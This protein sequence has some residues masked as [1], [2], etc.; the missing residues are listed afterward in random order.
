MPLM[1]QL[2]FEQL[3]LQPLLADLPLDFLGLVFQG[4]PPVFKL[5]GLAPLLALLFELFGKLRELL[6]A[7][8]VERAELEVDDD[9]VGPLRIQQQV[10]EVI[11][12]LLYAG[13]G[14]VLLRD[15]FLQP[16]L[17]LT[18]ARKLF[19]EFGSVP[20][21]VQELL[22]LPF[23]RLVR[24]ISEYGSQTRHVQPLDIIQ[25]AIPQAGIQDSMQHHGNRQPGIRGLNRQ[26]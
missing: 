7:M 21:E 20:V 14:A 4:P 16:E 2:V 22:A 1:L 23:L 12:L 9:A 11:Q 18:E 10:L 15:Q 26:F 24:R 3:G 13:Y 25:M 17:L 8:Q 6:L 19:L 5:L